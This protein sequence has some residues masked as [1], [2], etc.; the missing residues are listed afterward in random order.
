VRKVIRGPDKVTICNACLDTRVTILCMVESP[1]YEP[2][3]DGNS[4]SECF[5]NRGGIHVGLRL[6]GGIPAW[7]MVASPL[8]VSYIL[9]RRKP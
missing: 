2:R 5:G 3:S 4:L 6:V 9:G 1:T 7:G 8:C